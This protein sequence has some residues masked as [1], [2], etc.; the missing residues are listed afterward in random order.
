M[1]TKVFTLLL[2]FLLTVYYCS[3]SDDDNSC[4]G[5][6]LECYDG[7]KWTYDNPT[8]IYRFTNDVNSSIEKWVTCLPAFDGYFY[9]DSTNFELIENTK[10]KLIVKENVDNNTYTDGYTWTFE[11][12][13]DKLHIYMYPNFNYGAGIG[14]LIETTI[15]VYDLPGCN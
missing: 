14:H 11:T 12:D 5:D 4:S 1:K 3:K 13:A 7:T 10:G 15:E 9:Y 8:I 6:F 2:F